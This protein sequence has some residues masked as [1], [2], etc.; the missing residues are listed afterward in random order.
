[1]FCTIFTEVAETVE[2]SRRQDSN[3]REGESEG[4]SGEGSK[5]YYRRCQ[6]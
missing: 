1:M 2:C 5:V 4:A 3:W 6:Y